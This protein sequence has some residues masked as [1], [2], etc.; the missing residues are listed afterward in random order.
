MTATMHPFPPRPSEPAADEPWTMPV[1]RI[2][3]S[4]E[5]SELT[6]RETE[7]LTLV[8]CGLT[9]TQIGARLYLSPRTVQSHI[10]SLMEK[11]GVVTRT[12]LA[13]LALTR[14]IVNVERRGDTLLLRGDCP[15][16]HSAGNTNTVHGRLSRCRVAHW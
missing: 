16:G 14:G 2:R 11:T 7:I 4:F 15:Q 5:W 9:N 6:A 10:A 3:P 12:Q 8:T 13:V 1:A